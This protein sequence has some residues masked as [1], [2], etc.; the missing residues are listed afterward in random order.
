[1]K[2]IVS[3][4]SNGGAPWTDD[5]LAGIL[6][7]EGWSALEGT[8]Q[9]ISNPASSGNVGVIVSGCVVSGT[10]PYNCS[11]GIVYLNGQFMAFPGFTAQTLPQYIV[12]AT[13][14]TNTDTWGDG[15]THNLWTQQDSTFQSGLPGS[16]QFITLSTIGN[17][18][19]LG[20]FRVENFINPA[21]SAQLNTLNGRDTTWQTS[22]SLSSITNQAA[23]A[24]TSGTYIVKWRRTAL[25]I[26]YYFQC[27]TVWS[28]SPTQINLNSFP[29]PIFSALGYAFG[30]TGINQGSHDSVICSGAGGTVAAK[31]STP[32]ANVIRLTV[33]TGSWTTIQF[34]GN[35]LIDQ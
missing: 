5:L 3:P 35:G 13:L 11:A 2:K 32:S 1:M 16:G 31:I 9:S 30:G 6:G 29:N 34:G 26:F 15:S 22:G 7:Q 14:V 24:P 8:L 10:G 28:V 21:I 33:P 17:L 4:L 18:G 12:P 20:G 23:A 25:E 19:G 27:T